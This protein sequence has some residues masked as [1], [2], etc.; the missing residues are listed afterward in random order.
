ME[1]ACIIMI[2]FLDFDGVLHPDAVYH[3]SNKPLELRAPGALMMHAAVLEAILDEHDPHRHIKII[4]STSWV[5][6]LGFSKTLK[7]MTPGLRSHVGGATWHSAMAKPDG[8][9]YSR[10][11]DPF[12]WMPR[13]QQIEWYVNR[14]EVQH[15]I[16]I[17]DLHSGQEA[18]PDDLRDHL[19]LTDSEKGLGCL[20][21]QDE[22]KRKL[23]IFMQNCSMQ[24]TDNVI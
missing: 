13:W 7:K 1:M 11:T 15:W 2:I 21:V 8:R 16:A 12:N 17:D 10:D 4:L 18:W 5:R 14:H 22:L 24:T 3:S 23:K 20:H 6:F 9:P 19:I